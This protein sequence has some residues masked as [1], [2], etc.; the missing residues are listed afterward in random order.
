M[1]YLLIS[2]NLESVRLIPQPAGHPV[3]LELTFNKIFENLREQKHS[4]IYVYLL[5][6]PLD[7][8]DGETFDQSFDRDAAAAEHALTWT[9][10]DD[11]RFGVTE[12]AS[13]FRF[14][15]IRLPTPKK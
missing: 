1:A 5:Q 15:T 14:R 6:K 7:T 10:L 13:K 11:P 9:V 8:S 2:S 3:L 12:M 4:T